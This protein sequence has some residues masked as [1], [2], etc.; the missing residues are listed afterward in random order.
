MR[1]ANTFVQNGAGFA[2]D[3]FAPVIDVA[4]GGG[5]FGLI[6]DFPSYASAMPYVRRNMLCRVLE[7]PRGIEFLPEPDKW[8]AAIKAF[9]ELHAKTI[10]GINTKLTLETVDTQF[11]GDGQVIAAPSN[12]TR[13]VPEPSV[14]AVERDG[15]P[16]F[17]LIEGWI[18]NL[19]M[20]PITKVPRAAMLPQNR[21]RFL[22]VLP[23][24]IGM[25]CLFF[26]PN[27]TFNRIEKAWL[28]TNMYP[29]E[30][31][32]E[33]GKFDKNGAG[34]MQEFTI[35]FTAL[36]QVGYGVKLLAQALL[37]DINT[38]GANPNTRPAFL[39]KVDAFVSGTGFKEQLDNAAA[40]AV[41]PA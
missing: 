39:Q 37:D 23:D 32:D 19:I 5:Q 17:K 16:F 3:S 4:S 41:S 7:L 29:K 35:P 8:R 14:T 33:E 26:E 12:V 40:T 15:R 10:D 13:G 2:K 11:G 22:D 24:T 9:M 27:P 38:T 30:T 6:T 31:P 34:E 21:N 18:V 36:T 20:D 1:L 25:T 28:C